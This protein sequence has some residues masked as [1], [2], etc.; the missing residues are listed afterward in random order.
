MKTKQRLAALHDGDGENAKIRI[1]SFFID[2]IIEFA[3]HEDSETEHR[4]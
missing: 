4:S 3:T 1:E 2:F